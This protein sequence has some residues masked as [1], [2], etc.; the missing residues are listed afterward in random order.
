[1][2]IVTSFFKCF[3][4]L[5]A[6]VLVITAMVSFWPSWVI[7]ASC[8]VS[9][10]LSLSVVSVCVCFFKLAVCYNQHTI[11]SFRWGRR[12]HMVVVVVKNN[13]TVTFWGICNWLQ[14]NRYNIFHSHLFSCSTSLH[15]L[16]LLQLSSSVYL[17]F[18][19]PTFCMNGEQP[20]IRFFPAPIWY[21]YTI[22][23]PKDC[24]ALF[25]VGL[26]QSQIFMQLSWHK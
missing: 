2:L 10:D 7:T 24:E 22:T 21:N 6:C 20:F 5:K 25:I 26:S 4:S 23:A 11:C 3:I 17:F 15:L 18:C 13:P 1:M 14:L 19:L 12:Q 9:H 8:K 16:S